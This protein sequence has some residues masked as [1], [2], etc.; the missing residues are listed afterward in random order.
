MLENI[1]STDYACLQV[2]ACMGQRQS[3]WKAGLDI[4]PSSYIPNEGLQFS[5]SNLH[6]LVNVACAKHYL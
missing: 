6:T 4:Q 3:F 5:A 2:H 1:A